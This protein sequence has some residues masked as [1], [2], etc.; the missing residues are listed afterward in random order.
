MHAAAKSR[1]IYTYDT[2]STARLIKLTVR[3][4]PEYFDRDKINIVFVL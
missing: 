2:T 4:T 3:R 1:A